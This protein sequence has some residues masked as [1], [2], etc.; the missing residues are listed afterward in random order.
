MKLTITIQ[1]DNAAFEDA[2]ACELGRI[3]GGLVDDL[4]NG[5]ELQKAGDVVSLRDINGN[6]VGKARV[7]K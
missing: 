2:P 5:Q 1:M 4:K 3:L 7:S 6:T